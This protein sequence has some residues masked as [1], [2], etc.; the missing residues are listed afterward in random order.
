MTDEKF[1][2]IMKI[3]SYAPFHMIRALSSHWMNPVNRDMPK[4]VINV[5][6]TSGLHG[7]MGQINYATAKAG[8]I[9]LT[10]TVAAEW[11]R[12]VHLDSYLSRVYLIRECFRY[13]VRA[14]AVAYGW[15][16]TRITR[17]P[18]ESETLMV[19]GQEIHTGIPLNA[20]RWR[21]TSD[22]PLNRPGSIEEA[23]GVM[24]FLASPQASYVTGTC[25]ECT[26]GRY[27]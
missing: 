27:M 25:V 13:N 23:A 2:I 5:C 21:D 7:A 12:Y 20:K 1:D 17:P 19:G 3:H 11:G 18:T 22:I 8:V 24:L 9:G 16:D 4:C 6:S 15:I 26:G 14:N 10:K